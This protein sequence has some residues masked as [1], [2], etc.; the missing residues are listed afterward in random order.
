MSTRLEGRGAAPG[1]ALAPGFVLTDDAIAI[2]ELPAERTGDPEEEIARLT[3]AL[4]RAET[5]LRALAERVEASAGESEAEIFEAHAE[6]AADPELASLARQRIEEGAS[7]ERA[8]TEAFQTFRELLAASESEYLAAR[9]EDLDDVRDRVLRTLLGTTASGDVP[10]ERSVIVATALTPSQTASIPREVIAAIVTETGSP[11]SHAAILARA[12]GIPAVIGCAGAVA[13]IQPGTEVAI[14]GRTGDVIVS[15]EPDERAAVESRIAEEAA[16]RD[17]LASLRDQPGGTADGFRVELAANIGSRED[18]APAIEAGAEGSGLV[19]TE[20]LFLE[21]S[22]APT[23]EEQAAFYADVLRA[24]PSH[25]V[26]F[27]TLDV[28][29]DKPLA[30]VERDPEENPALGLRGIRLSLRRPDLF[31]D[32]LRALLRARERVEGE[33]A[34]RLAIM[35]PLV[36]TVGELVRAREILVDVAR[37]EGADLAGVEVGVMVEVPSAAISAA[38]IAE[39]ADFFSIGT[40]DLLQYLFAVDRLNGEVAD[41]ADAFE[42]D[43]LALIGRIVE[44]GHAAGAWVGVC[45]EAAG[46]PAIAA[47]F[48][49]LGVDELSMTRLAIP[50][51]KDALRRLTSE[52]C[53]AAAAAA[54]DRAANGAEAR[55]ILEDLLAASGHASA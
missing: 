12:L 40:N 30:F 41:L 19:R 5:E 10:S 42:P 32:Q 21:R 23:V 29:A 46:D 47:A 50:E 2:D 54:I 14:D 27:R 43:V 28:G 37:E 17:L 45:G 49:G 3:E 4:A 13:G 48:V 11:T 38:R 22:T 35:F 25:R 7:A 55:R 31:R 44:A 9:A 6:F 26:V 53:R 16:R 39:H 15:P 36:S 1:A 33:E 34:G 24:F 52:A 18:L 51:V 20:F 8:V